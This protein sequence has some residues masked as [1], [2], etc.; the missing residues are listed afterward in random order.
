VEN[1]TIC[2]GLRR[3]GFDA[4]A[5]RLAEGLFDLARTYAAG[6]IPETLG[7]YARDEHATPGAYPRSNTP[8]TWNASAL[9][10]CVQALLGLVPYAPLHVLMVDPVLPAWLPALEVRG[11]RVGATVAWLRFWRDARGHA[12]A[13]VVEKDG[14]LHVVRQPPPESTRA[15]L[16]R[17]LRALLGR[18]T[19]PAPPLA[20]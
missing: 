10:L 5:A 16:G 14:P 4:E 1:A 17:R 8:Q 2:F 9:P 12:H 11:L 7:G 6:R 19:V 20:R 18:T 15:G 13:E 3:F